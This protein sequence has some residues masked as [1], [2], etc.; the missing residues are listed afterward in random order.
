MTKGALSFISQSFLFSAFTSVR[1]VLVLQ[2]HEVD[3]SREQRSEGAKETFPW[4]WRANRSTAAITLE[5][6]TRCK[7]D[8]GVCGMCGMRIGCGSV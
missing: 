1:G 5:L 7:I 2:P 8:S 3:G 6:E 4:G